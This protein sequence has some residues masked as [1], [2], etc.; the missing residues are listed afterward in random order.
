MSMESTA[1]RDRFFD[2][3]NAVR[4]A[5]SPQLFG[6]TLSIN[7]PDGRAVARWDLSD[8]T[9][10]DQNKAN[11]S[12]VFTIASDPKPRLVLFDSPQRAA[13]LAAEPKLRRWRSQRRRHGLMVGLAWTVFGVA[14]AALFYFGWRDGSAWVADSVPR[15]WERNLGDR[16]RTAMLDGLY[17][18]DGKAGKAAIESLGRKL[19]P[20]E[21]ADLPL[22]ID[23]V[24]VK[25]VNAFAL[26]GNHIFIFSGLIDRAKNPDEVAG[27]LAHEMGHLELRHPTRGMIQQLGL[28][29]V[30]SLMFGGNAAGD[31]AY[32]ATALSYT[33]EMER[34]ADARAIVLLQRAKI[35][36]DGLAS[37]FRTLKDDKEESSPLPD[38]LSTHPGLQERAETAAKAAQTN[39]GSPALT[40]DEWRA[41]QTM[42][43]A[44]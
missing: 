30:I 14:L 13:L 17:A 10:V 26:P 11:G 34:E 8:M 42:C 20:E 43:T 25:Q 22:T 5:V 35:H 44:P 32:L 15:Q 19:L 9:V 3:R 31:V 23:V 28:S 21:I 24:R 37:F 6:R 38:W 4:R 41:V 40:D 1:T 33:R 29:A 16:V 7:D 18:C 36:T 2:G 27:V 39:D 12:M